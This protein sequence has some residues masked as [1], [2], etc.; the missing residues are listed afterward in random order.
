MEMLTIVIAVLCGFGCYKM[1]E[2]QGRDTAL[3]A[4]LGVLFGVFSIISCA[5]KEINASPARV[6]IASPK[7]LWFVGLPLLKSSLSIQG[8]S[9]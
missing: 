8:K 4:V 2:N 1:A 9:S 7:T 3:A 6:A 5:P